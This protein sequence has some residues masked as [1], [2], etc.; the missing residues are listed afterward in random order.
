[1]V[2]ND[3]N[4]GIF[5]IRHNVV[6]VVFLGVTGSLRASRSRGYHPLSVRDLNSR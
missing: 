5:S 1:M 4:R 2:Y 6:V 3:N